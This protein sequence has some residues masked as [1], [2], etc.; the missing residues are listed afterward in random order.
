VGSNNKILVFRDILSSI[1]AEITPQSFED[2]IKKL[3]TS[4]LYFYYK[5]GI[6]KGTIDKW[7]AENSP[8]TP[9][10]NNLKIIAALY[11]AITDRGKKEAVAQTIN[12]YVFASEYFDK[13]FKDNLKKIDCDKNY[14]K[15]L[16]EVLEEAH[17]IQSSKKYSLFDKSNMKTAVNSKIKLF[18]DSKHYYKKLLNRDDSYINLLLEKI[19][20]DK[21]AIHHLFNIC[22]DLDLSQSNQSNMKQNGSYVKW[23]TG[24][25][26]CAKIQYYYYDENYGIDD[27]LKEIRSDLVAFNISIEDYLDRELLNDIIDSICD[28]F[29]FHAGDIGDER[30]DRLEVNELNCR[31]LKKLIVTYDYYQA[32]LRLLYDFE[33]YLS[34]DEKIQMLRYS[35]K[36]FDLPE[37]YIKA[38]TEYSE[39]FSEDEKRKYL[40]QGINGWYDPQLNEIALNNYP[41]YL[42]EEEKRKLLLRV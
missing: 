28:I 33:E 1:L 19:M 18:N 15:Y 22:K 27:I 14:R 20:P 39:Y 4:H 16:T 23:L 34:E 7:T 24:L 32:Y 25:Y 30:I 12:A 8:A 6:S 36:S 38:L 40:I 11:E 21:N 31:I 41:E 13:E 9:R 35:L 26:C 42:S 5:D 17:R 2:K 29:I 3:E 37:F 10:H